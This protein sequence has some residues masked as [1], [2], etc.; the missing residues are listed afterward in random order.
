MEISLCCFPVKCCVTWYLYWKSSNFGWH[1]PIWLK[2]RLHLILQASFKKKNL[3]SHYLV[4]LRVFVSL[5]RAFLESSHHY[6]GSS[7]VPCSLYAPGI[8]SYEHMAFGFLLFSGCFTPKLLPKSWVGTFLIR[9]APVGIS[10]WTVMRYQKM[11]RS[12]TGAQDFRQRGFL[13]PNIATSH[14]F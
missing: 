4:M 8:A 1:N 3:W 10:L 13:S 5:D 12:L 7:N 6:A 2:Q 9:A 14:L 11:Q